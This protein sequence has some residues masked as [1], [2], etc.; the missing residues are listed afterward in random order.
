MINVSIIYWSIF[1]FILGLPLT[2]VIQHMKGQRPRLISLTCAAVPKIDLCDFHVMVNTNWAYYFIKATWLV[3]KLERPLH[4]TNKPSCFK[5]VPERH[6]KFFLYTICT[7]IFGHLTITPTESVMTL[8]SNTYTLI[9]S[10][11]PFCSYNS[12]HSSWKAFHKILECFCG[13][14]C[15]F[16]L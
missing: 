13:N 8:Y 16:I 14:W 3:I 1:I 2:H 5:C 12:F 6:V 15:P 4:T 9:W 11:S 10:W 7:K